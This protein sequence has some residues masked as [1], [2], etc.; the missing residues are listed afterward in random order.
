[1]AR[2]GVLFMPD[3]VVLKKYSNRRLYDTR[4]SRYVTLEDVAAMIHGDEVVEIHDAASGEDVTAFILTQIVLEAARRKNS[5]LPVPVLH[6]IIRHGDNTLGEFFSRYFQKTIE[7]YLSA[8]QIFDQQF[9]QWLDKGL[10]LS[11]RMPEMMSNESSIDTL[12]QLF[13]FPKPSNPASS[14]SNPLHPTGDR[15]GETKAKP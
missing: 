5:L 7:N 11:R 2:E 10:D 6:L 13:G 8:K 9:D 15:A 4:N 12:M 14:E 1:M 3:P